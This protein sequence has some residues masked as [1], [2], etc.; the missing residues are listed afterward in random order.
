M[1]S[2]LT[3]LLDKAGLLGLAKSRIAGYVSRTVIEKMESRRFDNDLAKA[4]QSS[5]ITEL[6]LSLHKQKE[7]TG[8]DA[9]RKKRLEDQFQTRIKDVVDNYGARMRKDDISSLS[10]SLFNML[11]RVG[12]ALE[13][14]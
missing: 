7:L 1:K 14:A 11:C 13:L 9:E 10:D 12:K 6:A 4:W 8:K 3:N 5:S 2:V